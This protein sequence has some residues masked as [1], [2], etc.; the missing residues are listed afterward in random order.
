ML[1]PS[2]D[3]PLP[4]GDPDGSASRTLLGALGNGVLFVLAVD[5]EVAFGDDASTDPVCF[6]SGD[7]LT[8]LPNGLGLSWRH[9]AETT[10]F[11]PRPDQFLVQDQR[12]LLADGVAVREAV[13]TD[14]TGR[15]TRW[16]EAR[17]VSLSHA[18][19]VLL[20]WELT[21]RNWSGPIL[22]RSR[23]DLRAQRRTWHPAWAHGGEPLD[24]Q[25]LLPDD[26]LAACVT[27]P[28]GRQL[29]V[30]VTLRLAGGPSRQAGRGIDPEGSYQQRHID[31]AEGETVCIDVALTVSDDVAAMT[32]APG[33]EQE[34]ERQRA[35]WQSLWARVPLGIAAAPETERACRFAAFQLLQALSPLSVGRDVG[36][37]AWSPPDGAP[38]RQAWDEVL[39]LP[40][41]SHHLPALGREVLQH[42]ARRT[43]PGVDRAWLAAAPIAAWRHHLVTHDTTLLAAVTAPLIVDCARGWAACDD[44]ACGLSAA[45]TLRCAVRLADHLEPAAWARLRALSGV[46]PDELAAWDARSRR[47]PVAWQDG[48][49][50]LPDDDGLDAVLLLHLLGRDALTDLLAHLG[51]AP[52]A[53]WYERT[54]LWHAARHPAGGVAGIACAGALA[55]VDADASWSRFTRALHAP[56]AGDAHLDAGLS[57]G[58]MGGAWDVLQRHYLGLW[59]GLDGLHVRPNPPAALDGVTARL[60]VAGRWLEVSLDGPVLSLQLDAGAAAP[61]A[62][63]LPDGERVVAAGE[64]VSVVCR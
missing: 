5:P 17:F 52:A 28:Q 57:L 46:E 37:P 7:T 35:A 25:N 54:A 18:G 59:P 43:H 24:V 11:R 22:V 49:L 56:L 9:D 38:G 48:V 40:F 63:H 2:D 34:R 26:G 50:T 53:D 10:W 44:A 55:A 23:L 62:L 58:A 51:Q 16:S 47:L 20:R 19:V 3:I 45:W 39:A 31:M 15:E 12:L 8:E 4:P 6:F 61:L 36:L 21:P 14:D 30:D 13:V 64:R 33:F 29:R 32:P 60:G 42:R 41:F 27:G 1:A